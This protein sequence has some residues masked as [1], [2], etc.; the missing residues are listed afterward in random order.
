MGTLVGGGE[1]AEMAFWEE[2]RG[3]RAQV[4]GECVPRASPGCLAELPAARG[5]A[6]HFMAIE[7]FPYIHLPGS[8]CFEG[9]IKD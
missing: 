4:C 1:T 8:L 3:K 7:T 2:C 9:R 6:L 5:D